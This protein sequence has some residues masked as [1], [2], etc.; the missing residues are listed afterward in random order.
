MKIIIPLLIILF[1]LAGLPF[2]GASV[3]AQD[4]STVDTSAPQFDLFP[5]GQFYLNAYDAEGSF[6]DY[7]EK[8]SIEIIENGQ[9]IQPD[10]I[11]M[12][13]TGLQI[14]IALNAGPVLNVQSGGM[15]EYQRIQ[16][17]LQEWAG[18]QG[19]PGLDDYSLSTP[20]GLFLIRA[21][22]PQQ[23]SQ[24]LADYQPDLLKLQ[25]SINSLAEALDLATDPLSD[26]LT[27]RSILYITPPLA[28]NN[29][30]SLADLAI[31]AREIGVRVNIWLMAAAASETPDPLR[32]VAEMTGGKVFQIAP[33]SPLPDIESIFSSLRKT[34]RVQYTSKIRASG[35]HSLKVNIRQGMTLLSS[36]EQR[37]DLTVQP[38]NP[39]FLDPPAVIRRSWKAPEAGAA[40]PDLEPDQVDLQILIEF[41]DQHPR[42]ITASRLYLD[43]QLIAEN[44]AE[45]FDRFIWPVSSLTIST[46]MKLR[47]EVVDG[48]GLSGSTAEIP[49]EIQIDQPARA[50]L[51]SRISQ[52]GVIAIAAILTSGIA[53]A[54]VLV[55]TGSRR[56][57]RRQRRPADR[58]RL[59][60][61]VTQ[62]VDI[63][64]IPAR[65]ETARPKPEG[66]AP[67]PTP[68]WPPPENQTGP[69]RL[70]ILDENEQPVTGGVILLA[71]QEI[72]FGSDPQRAT[73]VLNSPTVDALHARLFQN[74]EGDFILADQNS[75]AGTWINY[76][77]V[78]SSGARLEHGDLIHIGKVLLRF[79]I[80]NPARIP[81]AQVRVIDLDSRS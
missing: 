42:A 55:L 2:G 8:S 76:A 5:T 29:E 75:V 56:G 15:T 6:I 25:P 10:K 26:P 58:R 65:K 59:N 70:V 66:G 78:T 3:H 72:T 9:A 1:L 32:Q 80:T 7:L 62:P 61:P 34:Y 37:F 13:D 45:P 11:E 17:A 54:L 19:P 31:R 48:L 47:A 67:A 71:R 24:A 16:Q 46:S 43:D 73:Q 40:A 39:I 52:R 51:Y 38:P 36:N 27:R 22:D 63:Q 50:S 41:P 30:T 18:T 74:P 77:P 68:V 28:G 79:E 20:N 81:T 23:L 64:P 4:G 14:I 57:W 49:V 35:S 21:K 69:A 12:I 60:D 33:N 44:T 53:L